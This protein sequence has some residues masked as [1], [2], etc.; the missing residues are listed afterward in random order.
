MITLEELKYIVSNEETHELR[1]KR[2]KKE[3]ELQ[4]KYEEEYQ[5]IIGN[6]EKRLIDAAFNK[7]RSLIVKFFDYDNDSS[8]YKPNFLIP[9]VEEGDTTIFID[10]ED[11]TISESI[12]K[13][14]G[15]YKF[16]NSNGR[17]L[18]MHELVDNTSGNLKR[19]YDFCKENKLNPNLEF[20]GHKRRG[21][22]LMIRW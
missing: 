7:E 1:E 16:V 15:S 22:Y 18:C 5:E 11:G 20:R 12:L 17:E 9:L 2:L 10:K 6:L 4:Q 19:V 14:G 13:K 21:V 8:N 3:K